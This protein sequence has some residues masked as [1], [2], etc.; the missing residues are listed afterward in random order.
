MLLRISSRLLQITSAEREQWLSTLRRLKKYL[1]A[2]MTEAR[3][4]CTFS[5][6]HCI[7]QSALR[8]TID[9][10]ARKHPRCLLLEKTA[11][12]RTAVC[13]LMYLTIINTYFVINY[14][15][16]CFNCISINFYTPKQ[17]KNKNYLR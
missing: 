10:F 1:E 12:H 13:V 5:D 15:F 7:T 16:F 17:K 14:F 11:N 8:P 6:E 3:V 4:H 2:T 9:T